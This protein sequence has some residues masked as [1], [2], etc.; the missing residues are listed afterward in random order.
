MSYSPLGSKQLDT[1]EQ[2][3]LS[4]V[5]MWVCVCVCVC[6]CVRERERERERDN[7]ILVY[8]FSVLNI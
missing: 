5:C 2:L 8:Y 4:Y 3:T 7:V 1:I 6:V